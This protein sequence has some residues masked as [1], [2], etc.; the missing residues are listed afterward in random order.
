MSLVK[1]K[2]AY[3]CTDNPNKTHI[4]SLLTG[5]DP[6]TV[7]KYLVRTYGSGKVVL[8]YAE[9]E[10]EPVGHEHTCGY[11]GCTRTVYE[12]E[13]QPYPDAFFDKTLWR[14]L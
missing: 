11:C 1:Y 2:V 6:A 10:P 7:D 4:I 14:A 3:H 8:H 12:S 13:P 5:E 9:R